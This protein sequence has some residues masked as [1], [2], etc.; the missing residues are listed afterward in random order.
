MHPTAALETTSPICISFAVRAWSLKQNSKQALIIDTRVNGFAKR[1][2][3]RSAP[4][5][6]FDERKI[7]RVRNRIHAALEYDNRSERVALG[8][9]TNQF[10]GGA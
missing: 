8:G 5:F 6:R 10:S 2:L 3:E 1:S 4:K 7:C 9:V